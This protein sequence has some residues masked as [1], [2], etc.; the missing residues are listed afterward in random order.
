MVDHHNA[1]GEL[2]GLLQILGGQ[3]DR[4]AAPLQIAH[5]LPELGSAPGIEAGGRFVEE[6]DLRF[7]R[8][9]AGDVETTSH[10]T[11]VPPDPA[12]GGVGQTEAL[13]ELVGALSCASTIKS[14]Q[15]AEQD[16]VLNT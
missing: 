16:Q 14:S 2:V 12:T 11:R 4:H 9:A 10:P 5:D 15:P 8:Q 6:E 1:V 7:D 13:Q 3:H